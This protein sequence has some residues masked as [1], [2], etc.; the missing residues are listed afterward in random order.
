MTL[1]LPF[2]DQTSN[3]VLRR[4]WLTNYTKIQ[5][6]TDSEVKKVLI[7]G[8]ADAQKHLIALGQKSTFSSAVRTAQIRLAIQETKAVL[9]EVFNEI[10]P[11]IK[12]GQLDEAQASADGFAATDR[13]YLRAALQSTSAVNYFLASQR[14]SARNGVA[15]AISRTTRSKLPLSTRVYRSKSLA[16]NWVSRTITS[17][18]LRGD[19][20]RDLAASVR[21]HIRPDSPGGVGYCARRLARTELNNAFHATS[22]VIAQDRPWVNNMRWRVS[23]VH[24]H[25]PTEICSQLKDQIFPTDLVPAKPHP[26]CRCFVTPELESF[27]V[28]VRQLAS[29]QYDE[30]RNDVAA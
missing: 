29:G 15:H 10:Q 12:D 6:Q 11:I 17:S 2:N 24:E 19:S 30:W 20:A 1:P 4:R 7:Q 9:D 21:S 28:F 5:A 27:D 13:K 16:N 18:L 8:A 22:I 3:D 25:D 23:A 14:A 26:Q